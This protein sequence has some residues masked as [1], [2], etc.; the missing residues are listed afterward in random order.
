MFVV[1]F[2]MDDTAA[3]HYLRGTAWTGQRERATEYA[4]M[5]EAKAALNKAA[6][7]NPKAAKRAVIKAA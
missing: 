5:D 4:S 1:T 7:F 3:V 6:K 2:Q